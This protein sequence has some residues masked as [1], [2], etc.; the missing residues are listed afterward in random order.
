MN[1]S[2]F[3][4]C[5]WSRRALMLTAA[6]TCL[7]A[8]SAPASAQSWPTRNI[9]LVVSQ[10]AGN[11]PDVMARLLAEQLTSELKQTVMI[12]NR[13]GG[14]NVTG[15]LAVTRAAPD[16]YTFLFATTA[17]AVSNVF[18]L[19]NLPYDPGKDLV[20]VAYVVRSSQILI[21]HPSVP[22]KNLAELIALDKKDPGKLNIAVDGPRALAGITAQALNVK[23]GTKFVPVPYPKVSAGVQ[24]VLAGRVQLGVFSQS[25]IEPLVREGKLK[26][27]AGG[28]ARRPVTMPDVQAMAETVP[29]IDF[30]G[31][32]VVMAPAKTPPEIVAK[33]NQAINKALINEKVRA[34]I[35]KIGF[36]ANADG[37][38]TPEDAAKFVAA[39]TQLWRDTTK[40]LGL[41]PL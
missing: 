14:A 6:A 34:T 24:D 9:T 37:A 7:A 5:P 27:I 38:G 19:K 39:Q 41:E 32:F 17:S 28:A 15:T 23:A 4:S 36:E 33:M 11:S 29:G 26:A 21:A 2:R 1:K 25:L 18:L 13:P 8:F 12:E 20:P 3:N 35:P 40:A 22:A 10:P 16:G 30:I 31:W